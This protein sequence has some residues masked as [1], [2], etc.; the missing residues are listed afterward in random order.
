VDI[1]LGGSRN[2]DDAAWRERQQ[3]VLEQG[4]LHIIGTERHEA[5]RIDNQL[6]GRAGRQG[7]PGNSRF[8]VSLEDDIMRRFGGDRVKTVMSWVGMD[9]DTP[10]ENKMITNAI[11]DVQ[12]RVEGYHFDMRK[13]LVEYDDVVNKHRELIYEERRKMLSG[14]DLKSNI[15]DMVAD[16]IRGMAASHLSGQYDD[17]WDIP[18]LLSDVATIFPL[19]PGLS[20]KELDGLKTKQIEDRLVEAATAVYDEREASFGAENARIL[21]RLVMLR[22][23][24][25]L[26]VEHLTAMENMRLQA[27]WQ[28]LRQMRSA[29]AYKSQGY[30]Q[31]QLLLDTIRHDVAHTIYHVEIKKRETPEA[32]PSPMAQAAGRGGSNKPVAK[33]EGKKVGRNDPCPCGSGKKFKHCCGK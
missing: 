31:F 8:Y 15:L 24:D 26:W 28:T 5:R 4:G 17:G 33:A 2:G 3:R 23:I 7:D 12:K 18:G 9:E 10:I 22:I 16:E 21:E 25:R 19:P 1:L 11:T 20:E 27:G 29:D 30:Q 14:A 32:E 13:H 6:R